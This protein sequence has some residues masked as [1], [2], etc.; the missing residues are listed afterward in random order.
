M[1]KVARII[2]SVTIL[3]IASGALAQG[4]GIIQLEAVAEVEIEVAG[5]NGE[6][7]VRRVVA[8]K[9]VPGDEVIYT[10]YYSNVGEEPAESVVITNPI[11]E[12]MQFRRL[13]AGP[14]TAVVTYSIDGGET[15]D[16]PEN[17]QVVGP[18][19]TQRLADPADYTHVRWTLADPVPPGAQGSVG[20][21]AYLQ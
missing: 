18:D 2:A 1:K 11:P 17:L 15:F 6:K 13:D 14:E 4:K 21:W 3:L 20:F 9:V 8:G 16:L 5:A 10:I 7:E 19:S 12:H